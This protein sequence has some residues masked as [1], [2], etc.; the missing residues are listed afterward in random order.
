MSKIKR[1][2][3]WRPDLPDKRDYKFARTPGFGVALEDPPWYQRLLPPCLR[4]KPKPPVPPV[5]GRV[6]LTAAGWWPE[7]FDQGSLGSCTANAWSAAMAYRAALAGEEKKDAVFS[8][9]L[10]YGEE[11][12]WV[13]EDTGAMIRDGIKA[14]ARVGDCPEAL[15]PYDLDSVRGGLPVWQVKPPSSVYEQA[16]RR[17]AEKTQ[18]IRVQ[19]KRDAR[20][21]HPW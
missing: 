4:P 1:R 2:Y 13:K 8:R 10:L 19:K 18:R 14:M 7:I 20:L 5:A 11:R 12:G 9:L 17:K 16:Q 6:D 3:G 15:W 21:A